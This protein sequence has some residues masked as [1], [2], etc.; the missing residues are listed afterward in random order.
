MSRIGVDRILVLTGICLLLIVLGFH[1]LAFNTVNSNRLERLVD[2]GEGDWPDARGAYAELLPPPD[3]AVADGRFVVRTE[4]LQFEAR[5]FYAEPELAA[6][7]ERRSHVDRY[8]AALAPPTDLRATRTA[9]GV[10]LEWD[11]NPENDAIR[12]EADSNPLLRTGYRIYRWRPGGE[13]AVI[14]TRELGEARHHDTDLGPRGGEVFYS[15]L[16]VLEG[17]IGTNDTV[18][19][20]Q[21]SDTLTVRLEDAFELGVVAGTPDAA[22]I[23]VRLL[24]DPENGRRPTARFEVAV[25]DRIGGPETF[26]GRVYDFDTG[27]TVNEI[28]EVSETRDEVVHHPVFNPD[29]S[30]A[31]DENGFLFRD[32]VRKIPVR[33]LEIRC[34]DAEG[35]PRAVS[36]DLP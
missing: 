11:E 27:L 26:A 6:F 28:A 32:E 21:R 16:T 36:L 19:E 10:L 29:G 20:S 8:R 2:V 14:A 31:S 33:R 4:G 12:Q 1:A 15:V 13:P 17:R 30:R 22:T 23:E 34:T 5:A 7:R 35:T 25:G 18:I 24:E 9:L 3:P